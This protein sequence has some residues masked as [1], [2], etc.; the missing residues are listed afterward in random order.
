[1]RSLFV[2]L[3]GAGLA[4]SG[5]KSSGTGGG[6]A[7][8][9]M[10]DDL[11]SDFLV[12]N[13]LHA[14]DGR[15]GGWYAYGDDLGTFAFPNKFEISPTEGTTA[16]SGPGSLH[17]KGTGFAMWGAATGADFKPRPSDG[18]GGYG[19]KMTYDA[20]KYRG[21]AF[22]AKASAPLGGVQVSFPDLY[23]DGAAPSHDMPDPS[24]STGTPLCLASDGS[25]RCI[26]NP[27]SALNCSPYL[28]QF[29][30][31][32]DAGA[33]VAFAPYA[34]YQIDTTWKRFQILFV[35]TRQD[36]GNAGYHPPG[37]RLSLDKLTAM[38]IQINADY[39]TGAPVA[40]DFDLYI[41]DVTFIK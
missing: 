35:D 16:C 6:S 9:P 38:A 41:D 21:V 12:D 40:R 39:S 31:T 11:I 33:A 7:D 5:C 18:D 2:A 3:L 29:G 19:D 34:A 22:W 20:S 27:Q 30:L 4:V 1:M 25:C 15:Q 8:C 26:Y 14:A 36:P 23:T 32:G 17:F 24:N 28:V 13:S 37:D 10:M